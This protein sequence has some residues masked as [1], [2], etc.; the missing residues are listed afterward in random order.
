MNRDLF[1][2]DKA[3]IVLVVCFKILTTKGTITSKDVSKFLKGGDALYAKAEK[4]KPLKELLKILVEC[5]SIVKTSI[6]Q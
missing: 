4:P 5:D 6:C 3:T 1:E 2:A